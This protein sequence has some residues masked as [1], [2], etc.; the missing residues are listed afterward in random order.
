MLTQFLKNE[1]LTLVGVL[2]LRYPTNIGG[3]Y[4]MSKVL[5]IT[6]KKKPQAGLYGWEDESFGQNIWDKVEEC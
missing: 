4:I 5:P 1:M 2:I 3:Q 6:L